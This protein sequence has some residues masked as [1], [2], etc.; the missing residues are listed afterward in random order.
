MH[1]KL[2]QVL[3]IS[4]S[5]VGASAVAHA[6]QSA[7]V[8]VGKFEYEGHSAVCHGLNGEGNGPYAS[9]LN[10]SIP[11]LTTLSKNNGGV[12]P[13]PRVYERL[14]DGNRCKRTV[15]E[16]CPFGAENSPT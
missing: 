12:F 9:I 15:Q 16:I 13:F 4:A 10:K 1:S 7:A 11:G 6:Q 3:T 8:D 2:L 14:M 5:V